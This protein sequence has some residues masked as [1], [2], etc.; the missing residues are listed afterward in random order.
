[1]HSETAGRFNPLGWEVAVGR[2]CY[3]AARQE[4]QMY[5]LEFLSSAQLTK[6]WIGGKVAFVMVRA[7]KVAK[8]FCAGFPGHRSSCLLIFML[9]P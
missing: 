7:V 2:R 9:H 6:E 8:A 3:S 1:M 4:W 5:T